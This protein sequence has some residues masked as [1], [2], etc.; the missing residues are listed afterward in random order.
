[1]APRAVRVRPRRRGV[2]R[3]ALAATAS[4]PSGSDGHGR[5]HEPVVERPAEMQEA[6][7]GG[8]PEEPQGRRRAEKT[9]D[10]RTLRRAAGRQACVPGVDRAEAGQPGKHERGRRAEGRAVEEVVEGETARP[11]EDVLDVEAEAEEAG[12]DRAA[13]DHALHMACPARKRGGEGRGERGRGCERAPRTW[14]AS[15][16]CRG[17]APWRCRPARWRREAPLRRRRAGLR[18]TA[19][20]RDRSRRALPRPRAGAPLP[21]APSATGRGPAAGRGARP[22]V[23]RGRRRSSCCRRMSIA[24]PRPRFLLLRQG[25]NAAGPRPV[26]ERLASDCRGR[27]SV[28]RPG[29]LRHP[30]T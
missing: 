14:P 22:G 16:S 8:Q 11:P 4:P 7:F 21:S 6:D 12:D 27:R 3:S 26:H 1:M 23:R 20:R 29:S 5:V 24:S 10:A 30:P 28:M 18:A 9:A 2:G 15:C 17:N 13:E 19:G 25:P